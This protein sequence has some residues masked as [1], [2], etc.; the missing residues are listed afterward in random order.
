MRGGKPIRL[1]GNLWL[2]DPQD[3][4]PKQELLHAWKLLVL[5]RRL[6]Q[7]ELEESADSRG[8]KPVGGWDL[9][10]AFEHLCEREVAWWAERGVPGPREYLVRP[11]G[12]LDA[13]VACHL[14]NP[15]FS[16]DDPCYQET[17]DV[18]NSSLAQLARAGFPVDNN[19]LL[20]DHVA[21]RDASRHCEDVC[22]DDLFDLHE[23]FTFALRPAMKAKVEICWGANVRQRMLKKI[24]LVPFRLWGEFADL[25]LHLE[26]TP[27]KTASRR[28]VIFVA[29]PQRFIGIKI[30]P[31]FYELDPRLPQNLCVPRKISACRDGWKGQAAAQLKR[32]FPNAIIS[33]EGSHHVRA[34]NEDKQGLRGAFH[35]LNQL[36]AGQ[37]REDANREKAVDDSAL[38]SL[39]LQKIAQYWQGLGEL[40]STFVP[41]S[42][43]FSN[44]KKAVESRNS[45]HLPEDL[46]GAIEGSDCWDWDDLPGPLVEFIQDQAGLKFN[47]RVISSRSDLELA[48]HLLQ[49][50]EGSPVCLDILTLAT[51]VLTAYSWA[52]VRPRRRTFDSLLILREPPNDVVARKCSACG[53]EHLDDP[54]PYW[55][56][57]DP[58]RYV[59]WY[60]S[61]SNCGRRDCKAQNPGLVPLDGLIGYTSARQSLLQGKSLD[62][63]SA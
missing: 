32:A 60:C 15:T 52:I 20:F 10:E 49:R 54:F 18:S 16:V 3:S 41:E 14:Y 63:S 53:K 9:D 26:L 21:R 56:K 17:Q 31:R 7:Q 47:K 62:Q 34:T 4:L 29:H 55:S 2:P 39:R 36:Q 59:F 13:A 38:R 48:F 57:S 35:L 23:E 45:S 8:Q 19:C 40:I 12:R 51:T 37:V 5:I 44:V 46:P 28:F 6:E 1:Y 58:D 42:N 11:S 50:C 43:I 24:D 22:P 33:G 25:V 61:K 27:N 30:A